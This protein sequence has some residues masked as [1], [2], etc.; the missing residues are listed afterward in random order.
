MIRAA[1]PIGLPPSLPFS[2]PHLPAVAVLLTDLAAPLLDAALDAAGHR[3]AAVRVTQV[4]YRPGRSVTVSYRVRLAAGPPE[5]RLV[6]HGGAGIPAGALMLSDG[7]LDVGVWRFPQDPL[8]PGAQHVMDAG[9]R[10]ELMARLGLPGPVTRVTTRAYRPTRRAVVELARPGGRVFVKL[11]RPARLGDVRAR[12]DTLVG[13]VPV[14]ELLGAV[15]ELGALALRAGE[16]TPLRVALAMDPPPALPDAPEL[17]AV[18]AALPATG[19]PAAGPLSRVADYQRL[20]GTVQPHLRTALDAVAAR[21]G[22]PDGPGRDGV[23]GDFHAGQVLVRAGRVTGLVDVD[24]AGVGHRADDLATMLAYL[25]CREQTPLVTGYLASLRAAW[26]TMVDAAG[27]R[28]RVAATILGFATLPFVSQR[29]GWPAE[30]ERRVTAA[31]AW[32]P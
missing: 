20:L 13:H 15:P 14:P 18:Q 4:R 22:G 16:G 24:T 29:E 3:L 28:R 27:L 32:L 11:V 10:G 8:L 12:H 30:V 17:L 9:L 21:I 1:D 23:H 5:V 2:D 7:D 19:P 26:E 31:G 6:A 25:A